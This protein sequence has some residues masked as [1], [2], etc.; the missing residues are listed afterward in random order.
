MRGV[1]LL[2]CCVCS[3]CAMAG[4]L[5]F[6]FPNAQTI[7]ISA[8]AIQEIRKVGSLGG[9]YVGGVTLVGPSG[10]GPITITY[11]R[12][13]PILIHQRPI[14]EACRLDL[15]PDDEGLIRTP[16]DVQL[17]RDYVGQSGLSPSSSY[18][19]AFNPNLCGDNYVV[20]EGLDAAA[21]LICE[22]QRSGYRCVREISRPNYSAYF[23]IDSSKMVSWREVDSAVS[24]Y[25]REVISMPSAKIR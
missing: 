10:A 23:F 19:I 21:Y 20:R 25:L 9:Q 17:F 22:G 24:T 5:V 12:N 2:F 11:P 6:N 15:R 16:V 13:G 1:T 7:S 8:D 18:W 14:D 3:G 4:D